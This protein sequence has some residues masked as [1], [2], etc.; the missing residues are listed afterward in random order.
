MPER[1]SHNGATTVETAAAEPPEAK[2]A[3]EILEAFSQGY[4]AYAELSKHY[5]NVCWKY[6]SGDAALDGEMKAWCKTNGTARATLRSLGE[7]LD[8]VDQSVAKQDVS[9]LVCHLKIKSEH[10]LMVLKFKSEHC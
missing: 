2:L 8:A 3:A 5:G 1:E 10:F 9:A 4:D 6:D 7:L